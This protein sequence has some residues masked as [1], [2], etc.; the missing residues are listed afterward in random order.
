M[1]TEFVIVN[2]PII[3]STA[4]SRIVTENGRLYMHNHISIMYIK[5]TVAIF[6][7]VHIATQ[8]QTELNVIQHVVLP[9]LITS[10]AIFIKIIMVL[11]IIIVALIMT[12]RET[13]VHMIMH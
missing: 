5:Q 1:N 11:I 10:A 3:S 9:L 6:N 7:T 12:R 13:G 8:L 2:T 4:I